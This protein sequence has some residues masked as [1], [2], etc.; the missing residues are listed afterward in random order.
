MP[1]AHLKVEVTVPGVEEVGQEVLDRTHVSP[2]IHQPLT[3]TAA[4]P[5][6]AMTAQ[7]FFMAGELVE[8]GIPQT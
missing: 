1:E 2:V 8:Q 6:S 7:A 3:H 4:T 5:T